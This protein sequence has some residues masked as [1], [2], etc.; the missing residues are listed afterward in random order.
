MPKKS[1]K[2][3]ILITIVIMLL[4]VAGICAGVWIYFTNP[5]LENGVDKT[6]VIKDGMHLREVSRT[7]EDEGIVKNSTAFV[8]LAKINGYSRKIKAG[9][10]ILNPSMSPLRILEMMT[11]G[12]VVTHTV[13]I[14]EGYSIEQIA[15]VLSSNGLIDREKFLAYAMSDGVENNYNIEGP[16]LEGYLYPDTYQFA[17]GLNASAIVDGMIKRFREITAQFEQEL[18]ASGMTLHEVVTLAS[19]VE[20]ETG[21]ASERPVIASVFLNRIRKRMRLESDPT[22]IYGIKN[23]SGNLKKK[24]LSTR[25][26]YNTY[27]IRGLP[28]GPIANPGADSIK[29][30][31][32][33]AKTNYLYFVSKND[34]SHYFSS[35]LRE[36]NRAVY[37]YQKK[38]KR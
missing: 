33:P 15:A 12:E 6:I 32:Y 7:L 36:H 35:N 18:A 23:F 11:R 37:T 20:K 28:P 14:P 5:A 26:P 24:D 19:I 38:R 9:E 17:R 16:G 31:L 3:T 4:L 2:T 13:T 29:A 10:Y 21:K 27:V 1:I 30:V 8:L 25:T 22:V 34:G